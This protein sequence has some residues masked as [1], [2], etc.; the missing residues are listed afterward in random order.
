MLIKVFCK[1]PL[2][3][4]PDKTLL[5]KHHHYDLELDEPNVPMKRPLFR[6][7]YLL[8]GTLFLIGAIYMIVDFIDS[9]LWLWGDHIKD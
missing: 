5:D 4:P 6:F 9:E 8:F 3:E 1:T 7:W 2:V